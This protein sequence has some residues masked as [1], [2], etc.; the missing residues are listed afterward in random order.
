M[1]TEIVAAL[2]RAAADTDAALAR[3]QD[4]VRHIGDGDLHRSRC[5]RR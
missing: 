3:L 2:A 4:I 5:S 1:S